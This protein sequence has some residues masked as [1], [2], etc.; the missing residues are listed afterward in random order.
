MGQRLRI[1]VGIAVSLFFLYWAIR[2][3]GNLG[4]AVESIQHADYWYVLPALAAYFAGV[5]LRAVRWRVLLKPVKSLSVSA[6]FP[7]VVI[8]YMAN[9]VLPA[10]LGEIVRAYVLGE[11]EDIPKTTTLA[12]IVVERMFDGIAMLVFVALVGLVVPLGEQI[13]AIFRLTTGLFV[14]ALVALF[15]AGVSRS[16]ALA[17]IDLID[18]RLP[19]VIRGRVAPLADRFLLGLNSLQS[20][21]ASATVLALSLGAWSCEAA[22]YFTIALGFGLYLGFP[23]FMLTTAVANLGA[24]VPAAPGYVGTFDAFALAVLALFRPD[25][26][27]A[28]AYVIVLHLALL[29]PV[30]FLG[31]FYLWRSNLSLRT[32]GQRATVTSK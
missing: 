3:I 9:D 8:G 23:A 32:L 14:V 10:R 25:R 26:A 11:Q 6:L 28:G 30:T 15:A 20:G 16:R 21:R 12:T 27:V 22:M 13:A 5:W 4:S 1:L 17:L 18:E 31:F 24:M 19:V 2:L 7:V 29:G